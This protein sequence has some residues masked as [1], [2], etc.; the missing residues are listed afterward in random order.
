M[1]WTKNFGRKQ[2]GQKLGARKIPLT[3]KGH[4]QRS[5]FH[6]DIV[7]FSPSKQIYVYI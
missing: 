1:D 7:E 3:Q 5:F 2:V 4:T 6:R